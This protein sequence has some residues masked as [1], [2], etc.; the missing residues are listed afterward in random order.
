MR[1][2]CCF[3]KNSHCDYTH[4]SFT[5]EY[6]WGFCVQEKSDSENELD[7]T[8]GPLGRGEFNKCL[9]G[10]GYKLFSVICSNS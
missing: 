10:W 1:I 6:F 2:F 4:Q 3:W 8:I 9:R 7:D 5:L